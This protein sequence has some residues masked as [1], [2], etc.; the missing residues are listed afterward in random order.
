MPA[1]SMYVYPWDLRDE[2]VAEVAARLREANIDSVSL[3]ASYHAGKFLR[4][5][6][7]RGKIYF[8][9]DGTVYFRPSARHYRVLKPLQAQMARS[10]D[11]F[12]ELAVHASDLGV[13][14][15]TVGLHNSRL[16]TAH[17]DLTVETAFGDR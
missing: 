9:E 7:P 16:G 4:P 14:A 8:P 17:P 2:G 13:T 15:W 1:Y 11:A 6:G 3:T 12:G 10:F 5:H